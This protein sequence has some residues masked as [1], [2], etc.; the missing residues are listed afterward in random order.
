MYFRQLIYFSAAFFTINIVNVATVCA[1]INVFPAGA[2]SA[3]L[4]NAAVTS[5]NV[6]A[7]YNNQA[8]L[9]FMDKTVAAIDYQ[10]RFLVSDLHLASAVFAMPIPYAGTMGISFCSFGTSP[11]N[12]L[13]MGIALGKRLSEHISIGAQIDYNQITIAEYGSTGAITAEAGIL[14]HPL[15][16]LWVGAHV[17]NFTY[18]RFFSSQYREQLPVIFNLGLGYQIITTTSLFVQSEFRSGQNARL[19]AGIEHFLLPAFA[20]RIGTTLKPLELFAGVGYT[21]RSLVIDF[22]FAHHEM[23]GYSPQLS[24][25]YVIK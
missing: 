3:A 12:E 23:L 24:L 17:Y 15:N 8:A 6:F 10:N 9:G 22:A 1:E 18:S 13:R 5:T 21:Y 25:S 20:V 14:A 4:G 11:Y 16:N 2:R 7:A 19:K